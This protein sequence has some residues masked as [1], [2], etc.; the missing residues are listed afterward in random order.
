MFL[1]QD[2]KCAICRT[3]R[4]WKYRLVVDH[5]HTTNKVRGL[6]CESCNLVIGKMLDTPQLLREAAHYIERHNER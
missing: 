4:R 6:L 1:A 3:E 5:C 2:G